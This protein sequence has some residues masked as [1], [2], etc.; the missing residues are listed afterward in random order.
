VGGEVPER[1]V[2]VWFIVV[3][4]ERTPA[5]AKFANVMLTG[6][7]SRVMVFESK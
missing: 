6:S 1:I 3:G 7:G 5:D 2:G 4:N